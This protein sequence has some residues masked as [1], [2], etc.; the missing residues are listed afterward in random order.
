MQQWIYKQKEL[1]D[2]CI[3]LGAIGFIYKIVHIPSGKFY[4]GRKNLDMAATRTVKGIKKKFRKPSNWKNYYSSSPALLA[5]IEDKGV[6][7][8][9][10]EILLFCDTKASMVY[11]E[12][13]ILFKSGALFSDNCYNGNIRATIMKSWFN[14]TPNLQKDL[15]N[16]SL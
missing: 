9:S 8:Y 3:P 12:E 4:Y 1:D 7:Q 16:L 2:N 14:K 10:R 5:E 6:D 11:A 15:E 13:F